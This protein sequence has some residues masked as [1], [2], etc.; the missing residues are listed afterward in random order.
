MRITQPHYHKS[1]PLWHP[2]RVRCCA[3]TLL[4]MSCSRYAR[5][6]V[7]RDGVPR[8]VCRWHASS[9]WRAL[10][11]MAAKLGGAK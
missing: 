4:G 8:K 10:A 7:E 1:N 2:K 5:R 3:L 9:G 6:W 11:K